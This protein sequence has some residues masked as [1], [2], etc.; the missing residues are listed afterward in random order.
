MT[1]TKK[2]REAKSAERLAYGVSEAARMLGLSRWTID[3][4]LKSGKLTGAR[5]G[6]RVLV[7][8]DAL[9]DLLEKGKAEF[10]NSV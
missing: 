5:V 9:R 2:K 6:G 7:P 3:R 1:S 4:M 8:A 10:V